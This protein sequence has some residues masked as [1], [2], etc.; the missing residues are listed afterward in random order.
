[1]K[2][3]NNL[4][5]WG[6][7]ISLESINF[8]NMFDYLLHGKP[9]IFGRNIFAKL[10]ENFL[11]IDKFFGIL[12]NKLRLNFSLKIFAAKDFGLL[13]QGSLFRGGGEG[14]PP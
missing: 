11:H 5:G 13:M 8:H 6:L 12:V 10:S 7:E 1:M 9:K 2:T 3:V 4:F 14:V